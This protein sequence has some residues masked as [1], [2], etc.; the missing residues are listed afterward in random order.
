MLLLNG[1]FSFGV[2]EQHQ[3]EV[4]KIYVVPGQDPRDNIESHE[5]LG[6]EKTPQLL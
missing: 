1:C 4:N 6:V 3:E 5:S 2:E